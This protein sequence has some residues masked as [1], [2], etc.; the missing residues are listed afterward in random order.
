MRLHSSTT[1]SGPLH[2]GLIHGLGGAGATWQPLVDRMLDAGGY[3]VTTIDL[4]GHGESDRASSYGLDELADDV[5]EAFPRGLQGVVGHSL[6]GS[7]LVRAVE[8]L[9]PDHAVYLDPGFGLSLPT[10]GLAGR[11]FWAVPPLSLGVMGLLQARRSAGQRAAY[12]PAVRDA[13]KRGQQQFDAKMAT[14][15]FREVAFHPVA[16]APP[17]VPST[18]LLSDESPAVLP[19]AMATA[20]EREGW[21]IR[22]LAGLHHDMHLED[23]D[24]TFAAIA[25]AL[26]GG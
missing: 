11:A 20:L 23:P 9:Q 16:I 12:E 26:Q 5:A 3:T 22:R 15:V 17:A 21:R 24:R 18:I 10:S 8:R 1:G 19:D 2:V 6:G 4:R 13:L 25:D 14:R 7:V